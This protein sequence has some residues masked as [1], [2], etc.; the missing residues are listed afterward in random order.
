MPLAEAPAG[1]TAQQ[2]ERARATRRKLLQNFVEKYLFSFQELRVPLQYREEGGR[3]AGLRLATTQ[4]TDG[5][6]VTLA[7]TERDAP[8]PLVVSSIGSIPEPIR[9][10]EMRGEVYRIRD[11]RTGE[12][13]GLDGV[14]AVGNAVTG[15]GNI[16]VSLKHGRVVSQHMLESYLVGAASGYEEILAEAA[17]GARTKV[18][19]VA[20]RLAGRA[21]LAGEHVARILAQVQALLQAVRYSG[22]Y[23]EWIERVRWPRV[24]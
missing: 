16:L 6:V 12:V 8:S 21:P 22:S 19:A 15:K 7:E 3:L 11:E 24:S 10:I 20:E 5:R 9:G 17:T 18:A 4:V 1:A 14:F 23:R 13:E 2:Q